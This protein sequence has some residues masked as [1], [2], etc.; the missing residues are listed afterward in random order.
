MRSGMAQG[1]KKDS[2]RLSA[3]I[4][5]TAI[6]SVDYDV[7]GWQLWEC[8]APRLETLF[9]THLNGTEEEDIPTFLND[10]VRTLAPST[11]P[12]CA[13]R[14]SHAALLGDR[15]SDLRQG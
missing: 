7:N 2:Q 8:L 1:E 9:F 14:T 5:N 12:I 15:G 3:I 10:A 6:P 11:I 13:G 4:L